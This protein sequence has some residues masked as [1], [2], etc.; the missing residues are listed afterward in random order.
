MFRWDD[1]L[2]PFLTSLRDDS[3]ALDGCLSQKMKTR[4]RPNLQQVL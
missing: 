4:L 3:L 1:V 2:D